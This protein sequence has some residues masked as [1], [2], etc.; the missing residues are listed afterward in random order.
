MK[1][2]R[3]LRVLRVITWLPV[4]GI[5]RRLVATLPR[6]DR[7]RFELSLV[8]I[9][10]RGALADELEA[11]GIRVDCIPFRKRWDPR[12]LRQLTDL[13]RER[14]IDIVHSHMYRSNVP[15]TA[16]ARRART[17]VVWAQVHNVGTWETRR[18]VWIDR[19]LCRWRTGVIAVSEK[20]RRDVMATLNLPPER[21]PVVYNGVDLA[22]F[23]AARPRRPAVR[24]REQVGEH[25][26]V[27]LFAARLV[28]QKR[29][30]DLLTAFA[31]L[32]QQPGGER[33]RAWIVGDGPLR[34]QLER[35][36]EALPQPAA[37][38][39]FGRRTDVEDFYAAADIFVLP[40]TRE[41]FSNAL[42]EAMATGAAVIATDVGGNAEAVRDGQDGLIVPPLRVDALRDAMAR[43]AGDAA[44]RRRLADAAAARAR[45]FSLEA[46]VTQLEELYAESYRRAVAPHA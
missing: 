27:F 1:P 23:A 29:A 28:E 16:A 42:V 39:F 17:P 37:V 40:S 46:M 30:T 20:V 41:G 35:Q 45:R 44:L 32:Q 24:A 14:R 36:A 31:D 2:D 43:L 6:F 26:V 10:E 22:R 7:E 9:R 19:W 3:P 34:E 5:E 4:G 15:A 38:R 33:L 18:Q 21:V 25:D 11:A 8:C 12:A 13:M